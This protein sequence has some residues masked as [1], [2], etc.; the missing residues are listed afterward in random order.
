MRRER[1]EFEEFVVF[2][3]VV[4][5]IFLC[6]YAKGGRDERYKQSNPVEVTLTQPVE[7]ES[8]TPVVASHRGF[9]SLN[10]GLSSE[11]QEFASLECESKAVPFEVVMAVMSVE[12]QKFDPKVI[13]LSNDYGLMQINKINH[14]WLRD[15]HGIDNLLDAKQNIRAGIIILSNLYEK[16]AHVNEVLMAYNHGEAGA[17]RLWSKGIYETAYTRKVME[18]LGEL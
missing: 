14:A 17:K 2:C 18:K 10:V 5:S 15:K 11:L 13:S 12:N 1:T 7:I 9:I 8:V 16:Y 4:V 6:G 3:L